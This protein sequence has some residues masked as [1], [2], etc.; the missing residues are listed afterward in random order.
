MDLIELLPGGWRDALKPHLDPDRVAA[1][2]EFVAA[3]YA[4][5][6]VYPP[7]PDLF[8]AFRLCPLAG[9]RVL[10]LGQDPYHRPGQAHGLSFSVRPGVPPP[11]S[12]RNIFREL[13]DDL[14]VQAPATGD[15]T[16]WARQGVLLLNTVLTVRAGQPGSHA[17]R[18]WEHLTDAAIR[19]L[20]QQPDRV[21]FALWG[22]P[23][24][25]KAPLVTGGQHVVLTAGHPSPANVRGFRGSRPFS[26]IDA[27][28]TAAG[29]APIQWG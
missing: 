4:E 8:Q 19:T 15:L 26:A 11:P 12:L 14:A 2:A 25:R 23:A 6:T 10:I 17:G 22:A 28:L 1:L 27:A 13:R 5:Q 16:G 24:R 18:G 3:E 9:A 21:V 29:Q 7:L 20:D